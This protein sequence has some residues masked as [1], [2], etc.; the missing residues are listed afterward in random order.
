MSREPAPGASPLAAVPDATPGDEPVVEP[1]TETLAE[2]AAEIEQIDVDAPRVAIVVA[3]RENLL[4]LERAETELEN[5]GITSEVRVMSAAE[6]PRAVADYTENAQL[7]GIRVI[8]A[9][10]GPQARLPAMITAHTELPVIGVP[11]TSQGARAGGLDALLSGGGATGAE[12]VAWV[13]L[14][15]ATGAA[16]LAA[17]ILGT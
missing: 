17:R 12:P 14:D 8:I 11:L 5:R 6:E 10:A 2:T 15:D 16:V 3:E 4:I 1:A 13:A 9:G 7:R